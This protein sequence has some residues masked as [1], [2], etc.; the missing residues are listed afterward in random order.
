[1][2]DTVPNQLAPDACRSRSRLLRHFVRHEEGATAV[3]F[4]MVALPFL[5]TVF[6]IMETALVFFA[7]QVLETSVADGARLVMTG[8]AQTGNVTPEDFKKKIC[9]G[10]YGL[11]SCETLQVETKSY[12]S[13]SSA[14]MSQTP[15]NG[16]GG[17][18]CVV[19]VKASYEWPIFANPLGLH[20][21]NSSDGHHRK[22]VATA[23]FRNEPYGGTGSC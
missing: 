19:I 9:D 18:N 3:E 11:F 23:A 6:V 21:A 16:F 10:G 1:M 15:T 2:F 14:D 5:A 20:L 13:F 8:Q 4:G 17:P 12:N 22:I 7:G